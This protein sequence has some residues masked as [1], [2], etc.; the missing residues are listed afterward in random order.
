MRSGVRFAVSPEPRSYLLP[1]SERDRL[2]S[3]SRRN[4]LLMAN[5]YH[6]VL[7]ARLVEDRV[8]SPPTRG[9]RTP[10]LGCLLDSLHLPKVVGS[11]PAS[12]PCP[13][14]LV[15]FFLA[16]YGQ[17][18]F[19]EHANPSWRNCLARS[20]VNQEVGVS[21]PPERFCFCFR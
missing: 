16:K 10:I 21:G 15:K 6:C 7:R 12:P 11:P 17:S 2:Y 3:S 9:S 14:V 1:P 20:T 5:A 18:T 13:V 19:S 8:L 4:S